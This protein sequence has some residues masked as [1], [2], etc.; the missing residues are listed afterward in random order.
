MKKAPK[1]IK[2]NHLRDTECSEIFETDCSGI[3][4]D[5]CPLGSKSTSKKI[6]NWLR[7]QLCDPGDNDLSKVK[8]GD[9][10]YTL[11]KGWVEVTAIRGNQCPIKIGGASFTLDGKVMEHHL[12]PSAWVLPPAYLNAPPKPQREPDF[13]KGDKVVVWNLDEGISERRIFSHY[14]PKRRFPYVCFKYGAD[15]W[16]SRGLLDYWACCQKWE[17]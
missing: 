10:I 14:D 13:K 7:E 6:K 12:H 15:E 9:W 3:R 4:C 2:V 1:L 16:G 11:Y 8:V 5:E 17:D